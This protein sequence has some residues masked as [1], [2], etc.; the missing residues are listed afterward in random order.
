MGL[1]WLHSHLITKVDTIKV[2]NHEWKLCTMYLDFWKKSWF[3]TI[4]KIIYL[5][6]HTFMSTKKCFIVI[7]KHDQLSSFNLV[8]ISIVPSI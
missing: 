7:F 8:G 3:S 2:S 4:H 1:N 5:S 6:G